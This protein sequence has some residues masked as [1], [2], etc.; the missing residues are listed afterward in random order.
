MVDHTS[1]LFR[2]MLC[3]VL[4]QVFSLDLGLMESARS[5]QGSHLRFSRG[6]LDAIVRRHTN[7]TLIILL[8]A[9]EGPAD[10]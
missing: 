9:D 7:T 3:P 1:V 10:R 4:L 2:E 6:G 8:R 5:L